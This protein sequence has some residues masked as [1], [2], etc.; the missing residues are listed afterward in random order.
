LWFEDNGIGIAPGQH[1]KIFD[2]FKRLHRPDEYPGT[3]CSKRRKLKLIAKQKMES[4][5]V[6][7]EIV[8]G[9][10]VAVTGDA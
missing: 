10:R 3:G 6:F 1:E 4:C 7:V 5:R 8:T 9:L 2:L